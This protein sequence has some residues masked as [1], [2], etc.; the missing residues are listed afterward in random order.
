MGMKIKKRFIA[1][2]MAFTLSFS[3]CAVD[4]LEVQA[5]EWVAGTVGI[6]EA[7]SFL[8][9]VLGIAYVGDKA[10]NV[11]WETVKD[12]CIDFQIQQGQSSVAVSNWWADVIRGKLDTAS[13]C[14]QSFK[15]WATSLFDSS[16]GGSV[17][18]ATIEDLILDRSPNISDIQNLPDN[19]K[20]YPVNFAFYYGSTIEIFDN[21]FNYEFFLQNKTY[22]FRY[23]A[24]GGSRLRVTYGSNITSVSKLGF[25]FY[26][27][28]STYWLGAGEQTF[29]YNVFDLPDVSNVHIW[30]VGGTSAPPISSDWSAIQADVSDLEI[31]PDIATDLPFTGVIDIPWE[32]IADRVAD[33]VG[34]NITDLE[35]DFERVWEK[36]L[37]RVQT[38]E[39]T[40]NEYSTYVQNISNTFVYEGDTFFPNGN[41]EGE[42]E[43][44]PS[45]KVQQ[46][47]N[48]SGF[49]L[50]GLEKVFPFC[51]PWDIYAFLTLL[52]ADPV[53]PVIEYPI[54][55]PVTD[56]EEIITI[57][58]SV[59]ENQVI[60]MR[61]IFDFLFIIGLLLLARGL[62]GAGGSD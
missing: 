61:Y 8:L 56:E 28:T 52:V 41:G 30:E 21:S 40:L 37:D 19:V 15:D 27:G 3:V 22:Y 14:W 12:N 42:N 45:D 7:L 1:V 44:S 24:N 43:E 50:A 23:I 47:V 29:F 4:V 20:N 38:G 11:D 25:N 59:W 58:F 2:L 36:L 10:E 17:G 48:R 16:G 32:D 33:L 60:L 62:I 26:S 46:N 13:A 31:S 49:M 57:D 35:S 6:E 53:A 9:G 51:I 5:L 18:S 39:M 54:Y 34:D 55:N